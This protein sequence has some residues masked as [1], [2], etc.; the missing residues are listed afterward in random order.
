MEEEL[1]QCEDCGRW[2]FGPGVYLTDDGICE[3]CQPA[4]TDWDEHPDDF[5]VRMLRA[6]RE[7]EDA[8]YD[9]NTGDRE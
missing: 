8:E 2:S 7:A 4:A 3:D 5:A 1:Q 6:A 9:P